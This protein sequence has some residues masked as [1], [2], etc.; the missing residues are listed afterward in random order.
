VSSITPDIENPDVETIVN[1]GKSSELIELKTKAGDRNQ[2]I[3]D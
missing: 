1:S 2:K 3:N